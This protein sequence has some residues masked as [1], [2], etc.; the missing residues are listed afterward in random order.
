MNFLKPSHI[1]V[2]L[3][4]FIV[5]FGAS[6]LPELARNLGKSAKILKK[7]MRD[8]QDEPRSESPILGMQESVTETASSGALP[9]AQPGAHGFVSNSPSNSSVAQSDAL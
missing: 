8:L 1:L 3:I 2:L 7:E 6:K 5:I 9:A 4:V